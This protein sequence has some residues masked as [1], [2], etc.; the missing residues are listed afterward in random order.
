M[1]RKIPSWPQLLIDGGW[2]EQKVKG[3][4]WPRYHRRRKGQSQ[5]II[6]VESPFVGWSFEVGHERITLGGL[7]AC[8]Y[9]AESL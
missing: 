4:Y 8:L 2:R 6:H 3:E 7:S 1:K 5:F 9:F